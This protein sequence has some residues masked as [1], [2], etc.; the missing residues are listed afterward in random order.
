VGDKRAVTPS[1]P[2]SSAALTRSATQPAATR[3]APRKGER[4]FARLARDVA[5]RGSA[6]P[7]AAGTPDKVALP[8]GTAGEA[9]GP[10]RAHARTAA[11]ETRDEPR[12]ER[13]R[14]PDREPDLAP[15]V[16]PLPVLAAPAAV[17]ATAQPATPGSALAHAEAAMLAERLVTE[18][19][20]GRVGRDGHELRMKV[21]LGRGAGIAV[22]LREE[23]GVLTATL[24]ADA[25]AVDGAARIARV[26][27]REL[28]A[29]G[30]SIDQVAV[31]AS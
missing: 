11:A 16:P 25:G 15:F 18:L 6:P 31:E 24:V 12:A 8:V 23:G 2:A 26:L 20:V 27:G 29:R 22:R 3:P 4:P 1:R 21:T 7:R 17:T 10:A 9:A 30:V 5:E 14:R 19:R 13:P 28:R